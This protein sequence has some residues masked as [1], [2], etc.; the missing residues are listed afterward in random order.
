MNDET[1]FFQLK[2]LAIIHCE[3]TEIL[4]ANLWMT[5][6]RILHLGWQLWCGLDVEWSLVMQGSH[7]VM[8]QPSV[9]DNP[10]KQIL[11]HRY[12]KQLSIVLSL[13]Y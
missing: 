6:P 9:W 5:I 4:V 10:L 7:E 1:Y 2:L 11:V 13:S 8:S 3:R 12:W